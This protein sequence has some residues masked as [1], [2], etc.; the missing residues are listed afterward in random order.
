MNIKSRFKK[1]YAKHRKKAIIIFLVYFVTKWT[2][3]FIFGAK[4]LT[5]FKNIID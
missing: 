5:A 2:L 1:L 3:T 4:I